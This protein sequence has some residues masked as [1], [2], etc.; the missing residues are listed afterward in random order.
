LPLKEIASA[1][2]ALSNRGE[3]REHG[4]DSSAH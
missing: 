1:I 3:G 2:L 4:S